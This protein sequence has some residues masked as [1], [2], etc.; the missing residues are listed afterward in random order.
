MKKNW[1]K[2][3]LI[4]G[5]VLFFINVF[6]LYKSIPQNDFWR[7]ILIMIVFSLLGGLGYGYAMKIIRQKFK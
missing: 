5:L 7:F 3:G 6:L 2:E 1:V 4:F